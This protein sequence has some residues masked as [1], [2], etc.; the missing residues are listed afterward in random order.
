MNVF[1]WILEYFR[2]RRG[3]FDRDWAEV[4]PPNWKCRRH[5]LDYL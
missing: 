3:A 4:P 1:A 2:R 5:G